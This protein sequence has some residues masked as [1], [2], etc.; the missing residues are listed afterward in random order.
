VRS[1]ARASPTLQT[2]EVP[3]I[4]SVFFGVLVAY[5]DQHGIFL[6]GLVKVTPADV[7]AISAWW[8]DHRAVRTRR[9]ESASWFN[10]S[11]VFA[12]GGSGGVPRGEAHRLT[13]GAALGLKSKQ[14]VSRKTPL[15]PF[16]RAGLSVPVFLGRDGS[17]PSRIRGRIGSV[18][19][20][21]QRAT[22]LKRRS[23]RVDSRSGGRHQRRRADARPDEHR[24][25]TA[26]EWRK[27]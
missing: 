11:L 23:G 27:R 13:G 26:R 22:T 24:R 6:R 19:Q 17:A 16:R 14:N 1:Q 15:Q 2:D 4:P 8:L 12:L 20:F 3:G 9:R 25:P 7:A 21:R 5:A 10:R 18:S